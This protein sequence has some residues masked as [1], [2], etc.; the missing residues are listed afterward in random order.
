[1]S[2]APASTLAII[3]VEFRT[4]YTPL[5][6]GAAGEMKASDWVRRVKKGDAMQ[7]SVWE[8]ISRLQKLEGQAE[9]HEWSVIRPAYEAW[10]KGQEVPLDGTPLEAWPGVTKEQATALKRMNIRTVE[11]FAQA[12]DSVLLRAP[13]PSIRNMQRNAR[14]YVEAK[15]RDT[16]VEE[17]LSARDDRIAKLEAALAE[18][19]AAKSDTGGGDDTPPEDEDGAAFHEDVPQRRGP[20]RPR[21][22]A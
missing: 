21:K 13:F 20:G 7:S 22:V 16:S 15:N 1:M 3:P 8:K 17:A 11:D 6:G 10:K 19:M 2:D 5:K 14:A 4:E 18:M 9:P 12:T